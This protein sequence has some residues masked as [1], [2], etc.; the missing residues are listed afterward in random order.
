MS[1][2]D[3]FVMRAECPLCGTWNDLPHV[4]VS[5]RTVDGKPTLT[6]VR[7]APTNDGPSTW[8]ESDEAAAMGQA[9]LDRMMAEA[10][11]GRCESGDCDC[12]FAPEGPQSAT[13]QDGE[14]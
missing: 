10:C 11:T 13:S 1:E 8:L 12:P 7:K 2:G 3:T 6:A 4:H 5:G 14:Q 9:D